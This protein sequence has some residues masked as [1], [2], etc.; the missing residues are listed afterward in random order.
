MKYLLDTNICIYIIK[1]KPEQVL[2]KFSRMRKAEM[3]LSSITIAEL[4]YGVEKSQFKDRNMAAFDDFTAPFDCVDFDNESA[5]V[6][7]HL[8]AELEKKGT[9]I[10]VFDLQIASIAIANDMILVTNNEKEYSRVSGIKIE[11]WTKED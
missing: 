8:R 10:G 11:N 9:M 2:K 3:F 1:Q 7:G 6:F 4:I 5:K